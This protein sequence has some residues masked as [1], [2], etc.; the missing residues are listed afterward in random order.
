VKNEKINEIER[1]RVRSP[2][3]AKKA[4]GAKA[5]TYIAFLEFNRF[6][7]LVFNIGLPTYI[8]T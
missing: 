7:V 2:P 3:Q 8:C 6:S 1:I 4:I 5:P